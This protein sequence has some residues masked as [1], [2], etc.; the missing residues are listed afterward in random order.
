MRVRVN[1]IL[2]LT[3]HFC[4]SS[5]CDFYFNWPSI[6]L[7]KHT[8]WWVLKGPIFPELYSE[9]ERKLNDNLAHP[10]KYLQDL[11]SAKK[12]PKATLHSF[13]VTYNNL[14]RDGGLTIQDRQ[15]LMA[16]TSSE[17]TKIYTHPNPELAEKHLNDLPDYLNHSKG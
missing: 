8:K 4:P 2:R 13:R 3:C 11:L 16:H 7:F 10:R 1:F 15:V 12:R 6:K 5:P 14:L 9:S 17:T